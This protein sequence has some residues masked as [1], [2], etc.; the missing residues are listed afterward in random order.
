MTGVAAP[1][2]ANKSGSQAL[3]I[4]L[5]TLGIPPNAVM[6]L[7][8]NARTIHSI[9]PGPQGDDQQSA[10]LLGSDREHVDRQRDPR[11]SQPT[12]DRNLE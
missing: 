9:R 6:A 4:P 12:S 11:H 1:E 3:F 7:M 5:L 10:A 8:V 2:S